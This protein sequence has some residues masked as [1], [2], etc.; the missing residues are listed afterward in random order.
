MRRA[1]SRFEGFQGV[2]AKGAPAEIELAGAEAFLVG[3][4]TAIEYKPVHDPGQAYRHEFKTHTAKV[5]VL[6]NGKVALLDLGLARFNDRGF[7]G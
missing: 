4:L 6:D 1:K 7:V 5:Y 3:E 2:P